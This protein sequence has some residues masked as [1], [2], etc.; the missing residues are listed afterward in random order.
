MAK[1]SSKNRSLNLAVSVVVALAALVYF[2]LRGNGTQPSSS[3]QS[4]PPQTGAGSQRASTNPLP[5]ASLSK[6]PVVPSSASSAKASGAPDT[7]PA[8]QGQILPPGIPADRIT[9]T[10][11]PGP[12]TLP[13]D[14]QAQLDKPHQEL[15]EDLKKQL[16][17]PPPELPADL[18]AQLNAPPQELP[19]DIK[20]ALNT[21]PRIVTIDEVN[22]PS[23]AQGSEGNRSE[24]HA[25]AT[26]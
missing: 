3:T 15:P 16:S 5:P 18:K 1:S 10:E 25:G 13:A 20:R 17:A 14:L 4:G 19:E 11:A 8:P 26:P 2:S 7:A 6:G 9:V 22:N 12:V 24:A 23:G 21:P